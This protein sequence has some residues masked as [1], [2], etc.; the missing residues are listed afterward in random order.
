[1]AQTTTT[2]L[3]PDAVA[4]PAGVSSLPDTVPAHHHLKGDRDADSDLTFSDLPPFP[5]DVPTAPL[6]RLSLKKLLDHD[7]DEEDRLW[8]ACCDLGFFYLDLRNGL[9]SKRDSLHA[10]NNDGDGELDGDALLKDAYDLFHL[11]DEV[12]DL[13]TEEKVKYDFNDQGSYFGYKGLGA[14]VVDAKNT[15]DRNEFYNVS[16]DDLLGISKPLPAP[17]VLKREQ[18]RALLKRYMQRSHAVVSLILGF[19]NGRLGLESGKLEGLHR[20]RGVS[21]DQVRCVWWLSMT[22]LPVLMLLQRWVRA[23]PQPMDDQKM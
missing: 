3:G 11:G 8:Q 20:L 9:P 1:M 21:G 5:D 14:G 4:H 15:R 6:F 17:E 19:L 13:P 16:K 2:Q 22:M 7:Q 23:P 12:F 18:S 10:S